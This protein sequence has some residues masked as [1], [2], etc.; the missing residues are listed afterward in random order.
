MYVDISL[1]GCVCVNICRCKQMQ[2]QLVIATITL[3]FLA[4]TIRFLFPLHVGYL[5][6]IYLF[7]S[8]AIPPGEGVDAFTGNSFAI[9]NCCADFSCESDHCMIGSRYNNMFTIN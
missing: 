5:Q 2:A 7:L 3:D 4:T 6:G 1:C 8:I 9:V